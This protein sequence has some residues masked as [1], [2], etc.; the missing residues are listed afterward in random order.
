MTHLIHIIQNILFFVVIM[1]FSCT[2]NEPTILIT[3]SNYSQVESKLMTDVSLQYK[4]YPVSL[5]NSIRRIIL[6]EIPN[7]AFKK[8]VVTK[9]NTNCHNNFID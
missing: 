6:S 9:N 8:V 1:F 4:N 5:V 2:T 7:V 3:N